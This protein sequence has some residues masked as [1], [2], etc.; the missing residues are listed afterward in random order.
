LP[1]ERVDAWTA[2]FGAAVGRV[3]RLGFQPVNITAQFMLEMMR[4]LREK[5][6][7]T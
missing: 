5:G 7:K 3:M 4:Y 2:P 1:A 6:F